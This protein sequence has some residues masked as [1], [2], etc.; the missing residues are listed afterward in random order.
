MEEKLKSNL[1]R[2]LKFHN[3]EKID[4]NDEDEEVS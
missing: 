2:A 1:Y 3:L 4:E